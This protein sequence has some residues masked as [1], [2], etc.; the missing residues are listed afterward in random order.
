VQ[1]VV[2]FKPDR[3]VALSDIYGL[4]LA[5]QWTD[6]LNEVG[7]SRLQRW[8]SDQSK[9]LKHCNADRPIPIYTAV[10]PDAEIPGTF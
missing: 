8:L 10:H 4:L 1:K 5:L 9:I 2:A 7:P 6:S 3:Q